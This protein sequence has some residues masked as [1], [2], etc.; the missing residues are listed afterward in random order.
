MNYT[1]EWCGADVE[2]ADSDQSWA[3]LTA[4]CRVCY[5]RV[6]ETTRE[7]YVES[8]AGRKRRWLCEALNKPF[9]P[10][11]HKEEWPWPLA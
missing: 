10:D 7:R 6:E 3:C 2:R 5:P 4:S 1:C 11:D 9:R 8:R